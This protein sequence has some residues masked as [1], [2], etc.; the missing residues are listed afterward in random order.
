MHSKR[1]TLSNVVKQAQSPSCHSLK[2][3]D[4]PRG[5]HA[6][7]GHHSGAAE[8]ALA[9]QTRVRLVISYFSFPKPT[10]AKDAFQTSESIKPSWWTFLSYHGGHGRGLNR[11]PNTQQSYLKAKREGESLV[12]NPSSKATMGISGEA[13][14]GD[15]NL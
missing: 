8:T 12:S 9:P 1:N 5:K 13:P 2:V 6:A 11:P 15:I 3:T 14:T 10:A 4:P 7:W